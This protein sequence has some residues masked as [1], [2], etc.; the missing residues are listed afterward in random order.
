MMGEEVGAGVA[1]GRGVGV[2]VGEGV[3]VGVALALGLG[4]VAAF[5]FVSAPTSPG[6]AIKAI[7]P[8]VITTQKQERFFFMGYRAPELAP[9]PLPDERE[10]PALPVLLP[11]ELP[12]LPERFE[13][14]LPLVPEEP[15]ALEFWPGFTF[16]PPGEGLAPGEALA[17]GEGLAPGGTGEGL[18]PPGA[19]P[20]AGL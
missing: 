20:G 4:D 13:P 3:L 17:P 11:E 18:A 1:V 19:V 6:C 15:W 5:I 14:E 16:A 7:P 10:P 12:E 9:P 8:K 2:G